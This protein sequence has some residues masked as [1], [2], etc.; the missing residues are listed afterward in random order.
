[1]KLQLLIMALATVTYAED[2]FAKLSQDTCGMLSRWTQA[3]NVSSSLGYVLQGKANILSI[4]SNCEGRLAS[5]L[6]SCRCLR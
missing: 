5:A 3:S 1:M 6:S 2:D 4:D